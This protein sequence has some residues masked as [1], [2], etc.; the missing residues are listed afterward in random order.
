[1]SSQFSKS[2]WKLY[3]IIGGALV[4]LL[5]MFYTNFLTNRMAE[6]E[7]NRVAI[8]VR[9]LEDATVPLSE[10]CFNCCDYTIHQQIIQTNSSIPVMLVDE[11][12]RID[13]AINFGSDDRKDWEKDLKKMQE[14]G[15]EP[16]RDFANAIYF[17][18]SNILRQVRY[19]PFVQLLFIGVLVFFGFL[20]V[21]TAR[22]AE[23]NRVWVGMAKET[24]HQLG[25]PISAIIS[26]IDYLHTIRPDDNEVN[27]VTKELKKDVDR[28]DLI[29]DRFS[30]IGADPIL[31]AENIY[32]VLN[33]CYLY[34]KV[35]A[36]RGVTF[37]FPS[38]DHYKPLEVSINTHLF[39]WVIENLLRNALDAMDGKGEILAE[40]YEDQ[41]YT[42]IDLTDTGKGI[43]TS[44]FKTVFEPGFTT[45]KR[46][47]GL[48]LS[49]A[50]R[51]VENYHSGK[52]F[53]K[54]SQE[55]EGTTFTIQLPK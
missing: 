29:A 3:L 22:R 30:K 51:I 47:W 14:E 42:Y 10:A 28:L 20:S 49:L 53:V 2:D 44:K 46:G 6:E 9:A 1:M 50:K 52:I 54:K 17:K 35:R 12:G 8:F 36:P 18:E 26:W 19:F 32:E 21:N 43:P 7:R 45:K 55:G 38:A 5:S 48:G 24:A 27:N 11:T 15:F 16:I 25:T 41:D 4:V 39:E 33:R 40:V 37:S 23:Q 13:T 34:M 31:K